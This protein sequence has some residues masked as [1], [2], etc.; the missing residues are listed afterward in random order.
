[1]FFSASHLTA[2]E[3]KTYPGVERS[4]PGAT[5]W[6]DDRHGLL[7]DA[8]QYDSDLVRV[9]IPI[10]RGPSDQDR[11]PFAASPETTDHSVGSMT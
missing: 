6:S 4:P 8:P 5:G 2:T 3:Q 11:A 10:H 7:D 9:N 1:M